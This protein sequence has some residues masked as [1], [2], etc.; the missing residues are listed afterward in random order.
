[1]NV[2]TNLHG[3]NK[4]HEGTSYCAFDDN[5]KFKGTKIAFSFMLKAAFTFSVRKMMTAKRQMERIRSY[6]HVFCAI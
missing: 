5:R 4:K 1:M 2:I 6:P 3:M